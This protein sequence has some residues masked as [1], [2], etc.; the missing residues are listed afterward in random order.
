MAIQLETKI[1]NLH[2]ILQGEAGITAFESSHAVDK[3]VQRKPEQNDAEAMFDNAV[4]HF[5]MQQNSAMTWL[6]RAV[7]HLKWKTATLLRMNPYIYERNQGQ[8]GEQSL[9][10]NTDKNKRERFANW[11]GKTNSQI[12]QQQSFLERL[13]QA[14]D[15]INSRKR[16]IMGGNLS[17]KD[18]EFSNKV[19]YQAIGSIGYLVYIKDRI[20][21][22]LPKALQILTPLY[23]VAMIGLDVHML[24]GGSEESWMRWG[25]VLTTVTAVACWYN[26]TPLIYL[27]NLPF[28]IISGY[29]TQKP[30]QRAIW[31]MRK[32]LLFFGELAIHCMYIFNM[33]VKGITN[34]LKR[35][36]SPDTFDWC[37]FLRTTVLMLALRLY[38]YSSIILAV[39]VPSV[40]WSEWL[41]IAIMQIIITGIQTL[42]EELHSRRAI[43]GYSGWLQGALVVFSAL[44]F[45]ELHWWNCMENS[46]GNPYWLGFWLANFFASGLKY[47]VVTLLTGGIECAWALHFMHNLFI[48]LCIGDN[49]YSLFGDIIHA[50]SRAQSSVWHMVSGFGSGLWFFIGIKLPET[51]LSIITELTVMPVFEVKKID[52]SVSLNAYTNT[53]EH[54]QSRHVT[55]SASDPEVV[56]TATEFSIA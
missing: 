52:R 16:A 6:S 24:F 53:P 15:I 28:R 45:A 49:G 40:I 38:Q 31:A 12:L 30:L 20:F 14:A 21:G 41:I 18:N 54:N 51:I 48:A 33:N 47:G 42:A 17:E 1:N 2:N 19:E 11:V 7:F 44:I 22:L 50:Y 26:P 56:N 35:I 32:D 8:S 25:W 5:Y 13:N 46:N 34:K 43:A 4:K 36:L 3:K 23:V 10:L 37:K 55:G 29:I 9:H 27:F 39:G